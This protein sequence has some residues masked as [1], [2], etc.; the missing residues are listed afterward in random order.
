MTAFGLQETAITGVACHL[1]RV[2]A[3]RWSVVL[4]WAVIFLLWCVTVQLSLL[5]LNSIVA[6]TASGLFL[7]ELVLE[8]IYFII[9]SLQFV[10]ECRVLHWFRTLLNF[11]SSDR[12]DVF[13]E[14]EFF[15]PHCFSVLCFNHLLSRRFVKFAGHKVLVG[16]YILIKIDDFVDRYL[17]RLYFHGLLCEAKSLLSRDTL[18]PHFSTENFLILNMNYTRVK[19][20]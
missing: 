8:Q 20:Q 1:V 11:I 3:H 5:S 12:R 6:D 15:Y 10:V 9:K 17:R 4:S 16:V 13:V 19:L 18:S 7:V 14:L 2:F